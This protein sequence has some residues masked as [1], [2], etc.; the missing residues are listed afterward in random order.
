M[1]NFVFLSVVVMAVSF[2]WQAKARAETLSSIHKPFG[3]GV[4]VGEPTG[5]NAKVWIT[6]DM[7]LDFG[8]GYAFSEYFVM[9]GDILWHFRDV[10]NVRDGLKGALRPYVGGGLGLELATVE[11]RRHDVWLFARLP[12]G[13]EW[14]LDRPSIAVF[15]EIVPGLEVAPRME[16]LMQGVVGARFRF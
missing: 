2:C 8:F 11:S 16:F 13:I 1:K 9:Y 12:L 4:M 5:L 3:L 6:R 14:L 7:G 10:A 15:G